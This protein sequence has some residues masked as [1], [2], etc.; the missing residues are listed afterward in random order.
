MELDRNINPDGLGKYALINLR[1]LNETCAEQSAFLRWTREVE[2]ALAVLEKAGVL[3][4]GQK[5]SETEFFLIKLRDIYAPD[6]LLA[7][8]KAAIAGGDSQ[9]G[10]QVWDLAARSGIASPHAK[11]PD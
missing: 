2:D 9:F 5:G 3:E 10:A 8:A 1:K 4:W 11:R 6:A 7:Y